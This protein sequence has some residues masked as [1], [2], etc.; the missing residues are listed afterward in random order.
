M[1]VRHL[2][3]ACSLAAALASAQPP[4]FE[5]ASV[6][7]HKYVPGERRVVEF[8]CAPN[9]RFVSLGQGLRTSLLWT[10]DIRNKPHLLAG[11][12]SWVDT[13]DALFD[14]EAKAATNVS[15]QQC[16][17]MYQTLLADRFH[18]VYHREQREIPVYALVVAKSGPK[19]PQASDS[20]PSP[21]SGVKLTVNG[22]RVGAAPGA[23]A[24][25]TKPPKGWTMETLATFINLGQDK[26]ILDRTALAGLYKITL[27]YGVSFAPGVP[28]GTD[29]P[30]LSTALQEQLG[31]KLEERKEPFSVIVI[32]HLERP[33]AN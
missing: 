1:P 15:E 21:E 26:P 31:L 17:E 10:F 11:L 5:V 2:L 6:K 19:M 20:D 32:D 25:D 29:D 33:D 30:E 14:I 12:P 9:G 28:T 22:S 27:S 23:S 16:R 4:S 8:G 24:Q 13:T 18:L 7:P 3:A